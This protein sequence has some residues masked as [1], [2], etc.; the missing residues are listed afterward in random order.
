V[1]R[2]QLVALSPVGERERMKAV[3]GAGDGVEL[4]D[5][6]EPPGRGELLTMRAVSIC[7]SDFGYIAGGSRFVLGH[8]LAGLR[9]DGT[10]VAIEAIFGCMA[11]E[12]CRRG[13]FN[14]C[15][16]QP[17]EALGMT[18]HG[19]MAEHFR[20]PENRLVPLPP[21]LDVR[22][23][24][25]VEPASV[26]WH[27]LRLAGTGPGTRVAVVG[28]GAIGQMAV[29][30]ALRQGAS[31]VAL[32]ARYDRQREVG[33]RLGAGTVDGLYDVVIEAAGS[34]S[35]VDRC[36]QLVAPGGSI[37]VLGVHYAGFS[38]DFISL[39]LKEARI[40]PS[41]GY[42][43]HDG[44]SDMAQAAEMLAAQPDIVDALVTHRFPL[45]DA[46]EAFRVAQDRKA[47]AL[48]VVIEV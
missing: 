2:I 33:E 41:I 17:E 37:V 21:G 27:G 25:L 13:A 1:D 12:Y 28:G 48:K 46:A 23:G 39:L 8:E 45:E 44:G 11:C 15:P 24:S 38:P 14:L 35:S 40:V 34:A 22:D 47:G 4:V 7:G 19:G 6:D 3:R 18:A 29:A 10:P 5:V 31:E 9:A 32:E 30:G 42:C 26:A 36:V 43:H 20:A 16:R